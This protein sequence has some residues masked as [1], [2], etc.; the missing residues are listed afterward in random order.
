MNV[1]ASIVPPAQRFCLLLGTTLTCFVSAVLLVSSL[2]LA[3]KVPFTGD[4]VLIAA[5]LAI[6]C[7]WWDSGHYF[8]EDRLR[9][10]G[11]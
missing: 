6:G 9:A 8:P 10:F 5:V 1:Q 7:A 11:L 4:A 3:V 2:L